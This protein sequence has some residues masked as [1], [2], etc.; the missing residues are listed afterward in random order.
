MIQPE[1][2][3]PISSLL[4]EVRTVECPEHGAYESRKTRF[5]GKDIWTGCPVC[6]EEF[7]QQQVRDQERA[8]R[9]AAR[10]RMMQSAAI[11]ARFADRKL[12]NF[13]AETEG[14]RRALRVSTRFAEDFAD[15]LGAGRSMIFCGRPGTGKTHLAIG[16]AHAIIA[17]GYTAVFT[18]AMDAVRTVRETYRKDSPKTEREVVRDFAV[19][20]LAVIDEVG[21]QLG[22]E[23]E[24]MTL[25]ELINARYLALRPMIV[26][27]NL[28]LR[29][30][31]QYIGE[32]AFDR[33]RENGGRVVLFDWESYRRRG[34]HES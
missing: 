3:Q 1:R 34:N 30:V 21:A 23:A 32:R 18:T 25:F 4:A 11:P 28:T 27:S 24:K 13:V 7:G 12:E 9:E 29:E 33:L 16:I 6:I 15:A 31:E 19:A 14:Q 26:I 20:D 10:L 17:R 5:P 22:T 2:I 8:R